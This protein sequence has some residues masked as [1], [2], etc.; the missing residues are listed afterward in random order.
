M[1]PTSIWIPSKSLGMGVFLWNYKI[2]WWM[3]PNDQK[4]IKWIVLY[5]SSFEQTSVGFC[6]R[7]S[8]G[9]S[10][11]VVLSDI[12]I[13]RAGCFENNSDPPSDLRLFDF[14]FLLFWYF[15]SC[16]QYRPATS[17]EHQMVISAV[18]KIT[19]LLITRPSKIFNHI[20]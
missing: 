9:T 16:T 19:L 12:D 7:N 4:G 10:W 14:E 18:K 3:T 6:W 20:Y 13:T 1:L 5:L 15:F 17:N 2:L 8:G 11:L